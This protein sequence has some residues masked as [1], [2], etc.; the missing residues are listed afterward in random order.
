MTATIASVG[1]LRPGVGLVGLREAG[2]API[3]FLYG[4]A[5]QF[6]DAHTL[7]ESAAAQILVR[8]GIESQMRELVGLHVRLLRVLSHA[9]S[10]TRQFYHTSPLLC[11]TRTGVSV[12]LCLHN[13]R[14]TRRLRL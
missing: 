11:Y 6:S 1:A 13:G 5:D 9:Q 10:I 4:A 8:V 3:G 7:L 12:P 14:T 2:F